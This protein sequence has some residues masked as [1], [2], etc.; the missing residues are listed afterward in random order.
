MIV[1]EDANLMMEEKTM[2]PTIVANF[3]VSKNGTCINGV[4][5]VFIV[6]SSEAS[7]LLH[8]LVSLF[9][10][11][12]DAISTAYIHRKKLTPIAHNDPQRLR[13]VRNVLAAKRLEIK[14]YFLFNFQLKDDE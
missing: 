11:E 10:R 7:S 4:C 6:S 5:V 3:A 13:M 1:P 14:K 8:S 9:F 12:D 2:T